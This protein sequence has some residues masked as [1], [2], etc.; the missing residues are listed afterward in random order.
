MP[1]IMPFGMPEHLPLCARGM[2]TDV[3]NAETLF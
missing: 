3:E 1:V 2:A